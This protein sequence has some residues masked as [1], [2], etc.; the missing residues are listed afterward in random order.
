M[1]HLSLLEN[2]KLLLRNGDEAGIIVGFGILDGQLTIFIEEDMGL[3]E[4]DD[5]DDGEEV[6]EDT[7]EPLLKV[8]GGT[9]GG[10]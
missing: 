4:E 2:A 8:V 10:V 3:E 9:H 5:P 1:D 7:P 6:P